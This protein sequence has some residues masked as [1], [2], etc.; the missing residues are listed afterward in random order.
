[1][2]HDLTVIITY[3]INTPENYEIDGNVRAVSM[4]DFLA[5]CVRS[6]IGAGKDIS[7]PNQP[8]DGKFIIRINCDPSHDSFSVTS[9]CGN[10]G[11]ETGIIR[12]VL[13]RV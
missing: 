6:H 11:L 13:S 7:K 3:P 9:N 12:D 4:G 10:K 5:S 2:G 1:M 8:E